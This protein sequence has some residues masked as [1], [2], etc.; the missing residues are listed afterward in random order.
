[1]N[2]RK[3][4]KESIDEVVRRNIMEYG[5]SKEDGEI[6][7]LCADTLQE[8]HD[9]ILK[10]N[11]GMTEREASLF[12]LQAIINKLRKLQTTIR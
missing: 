12:S 7:K 11:K 9:D 2:I 5:R 6:I 3:I 8:L 10:K 4:I 1:M